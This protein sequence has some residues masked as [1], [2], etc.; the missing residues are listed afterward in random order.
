MRKFLGC[1]EPELKDKNALWTAREIE[2]QPQVWKTVAANI[3]DIRPEIDDWLGGI[4]SDPSTR[5][6]LTGAGTSAYVG[7]TAA[8]YLSKILSRPVEA[9]STTNIVASPQLHLIND[10]A[11][12]MISYARSG[13]SPESVAACELC[14]QLLNNVYHLIIT[15]NKNGALASIKNEQNNR[16]V[17][18]MPDETNDKSFAM[19][20]SFTSMLLSTFTIFDFHNDMFSKAIEISEYILS[21]HVIGKIMDVGDKPFKRA[22]FLG[23]G[24]LLGIAQEAALKMLELSAGELD[25]YFES[26][27]GFRHGPKLIIDENT[28]VVILRSNHP[29]CKKYDNDLVEEI[30]SD[31]QTD[32]IVD[33]LNY[34]EFSPADIDDVWLTF[35][36]ILFCQ[37]LAFHKSLALNNTPD[38]PCPTGEANRVVQGV[39]IYPYGE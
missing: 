22:V 11:T 30:R 38:N 26:P 36:Y 23:A 27:M 14:D 25:C 3:A 9:I 16:F 34:L 18:L 39:Q 37:I 5:I 8:P 24:G 21:V 6:I 1:S 13:N 2:Q 17:L 7:E 33:V 32:H 19:T 15:C 29:Y 12:L 28:L 10:R 20:S 31:K 35:P 4:L